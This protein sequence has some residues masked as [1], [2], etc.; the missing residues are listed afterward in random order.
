MNASYGSMDDALE[1][2][3]AYGPDLQN[4][5]TNHAPMAAEAMCAMGRPEAV[6]PWIEHYRA[7][8]LPRPPAREP[9]TTADWRSA[10]GREDRFGDWSAFFADELQQ[11]SWR[12]VL[13]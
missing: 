2:L 8:M 10:L 13:E 12:V 3:V 11:A 5:L 4:G 1:I 6:R 9:I 7:G